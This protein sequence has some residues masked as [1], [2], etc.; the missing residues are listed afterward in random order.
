MKLQPFRLC[1]FAPL[2]AL[3]LSCDGNTPVAP[4]P[5]Q[6]WL[7]ALIRDFEMQPVANPPVSI[8][9]YEYKSDVVYF[10]PPRCCDIWS[11]LYRADGTTLC[12]PNGGLTGNGDERCPDFFAEGKNPQIIWQDPR[13]GR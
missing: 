9:R 3:C 5:A 6:A 7:P 2:C 8:T 1:V 12:H 11:D 13:S 4:E 10:V